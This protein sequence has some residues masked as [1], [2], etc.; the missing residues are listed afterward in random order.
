MT[1]ITL[2][3]FALAAVAGVVGCVGDPSEDEVVSRARQRTYSTDT[4]SSTVATTSGTGGC[5]YGTGGSTSESV[6]TGGDTSATTSSTGD[7]GACQVVV[8][9]DLSACIEPGN[10]RTECGDLGLVTIGKDDDLNGL[11]FTATMDAYVA[12]VASGRG[13]CARGTRSASIYVDVSEGDVLHP[14]GGQGI[15]H[16]TYCGCPSDGGPGAWPD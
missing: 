12:I 4:T 8:V 10:P 3:A 2:S 14:P 9:E 1:K 15:S 6:T 7:G 13:E 11:S 5:N 16:V